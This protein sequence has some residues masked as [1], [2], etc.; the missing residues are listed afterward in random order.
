MGLGA[1]AA[2]S[3]CAQPGW[4]AEPTPV[5]CPG[6]PTAVETATAGEVL[7]L[8]AGVCEVNLAIANTAA[9]TLEGASAGTTTL[10][11]KKAAEPIIASEASVRFTL[12]RLTFTGATNDGA[13]RPGRQKRKPGPGRDAARGHLR[14]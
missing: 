12:S 8:P 14:R 6:L 2:L 7:Q 11:P 13:D 1:I 10:K 9:F 5:S 3:V 4:A